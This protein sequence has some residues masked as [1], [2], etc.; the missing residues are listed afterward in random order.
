MDRI[1]AIPGVEAVGAADWLPVSPGGGPWNALSRQDRPL[2]EGEM[3]TPGT[4]K[5]VSADYFETL[6]APMV[7][8]RTFKIAPLG[9][10]A[11]PL[12]CR[13]GGKAA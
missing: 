12:T 9:T 2:E 10:V 7:A 13:T 4:R 6:G 11:N 8:G 3:G 5:F 1:R